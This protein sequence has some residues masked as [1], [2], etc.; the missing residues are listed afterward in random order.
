MVVTRIKA[1]VLH[2]G[3]QNLPGHVSFSSPLL[4][5]YQPHWV[6]LGMFHLRNV[7]RPSSTHSGLCLTIISSENPSQIA[8]R[9]STQFLFL[10]LSTLLDVFDSYSHYLQLF[11]CIYQLSCSLRQKLCEEKRACLAHCCIHRTFPGMEQAPCESS[12]LWN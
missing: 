6:L 4:P 10:C 8:R 1:K 12:Q 9:Y 5:S 3:L 11:L 7:T 2:L